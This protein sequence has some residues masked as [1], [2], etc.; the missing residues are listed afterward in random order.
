MI[1]ETD[2]AGEYPVFPDTA[3]V[4]GFQY[5][6]KLAYLSGNGA[7]PLATAGITGLLDRYRRF[8]NIPGT[9]TVLVVF[10]ETGLTAFI[11][12]PVHELFDLSLSLEHFFPRQAVCDV[13]ERLAEVSTD[14]ERLDVVEAFLLAR[15]AEPRPDPVVAGALEQIYL[16]GGNIRIGEL[17][18]ALHIS[19]SPLEKRFR[20]AV[21]ASPKKFAGIVRIKKMISALDRG[22]LDSMDYLDD[23]YDQAHFIKDFKRFTAM[24]PEEYLKERG[25]R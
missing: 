21:G 1:S 14:R 2:A 20:R 18:A 25:K 16:C 6:G 10:R 19:Q 4:M 23:Y 15:L 24:T 8:R 5:A 22:Y 9:G 17:A 12:Q 13:E 7:E 11:R 3:L